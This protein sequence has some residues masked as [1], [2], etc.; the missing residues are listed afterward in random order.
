[1]L[2]NLL[3]ALF[4]PHF[5]IVARMFQFKKQHRKRFQVKFHS[6]KS[7]CENDPKEFVE[8]FYCTIMLAKR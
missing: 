1:M 4:Y 2:W 3:T 7:G 8:L 6:L 5:A